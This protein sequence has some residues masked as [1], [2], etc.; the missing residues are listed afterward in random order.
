MKKRLPF[1]P[2]WLNLIFILA[3]FALGAFHEYLCA[4]LS[5][6]LLTALLIRFHRKKELAFSASPVNVILL[7][8]PFLY[9]LT[10]LWATDRGIALMGF[11]K[12]LPLS[13]FT[14]LLSDGE[15]EREE[16][17][18]LL[19]FVGGAQA[20]LSAGLMQIPVLKGF[21]SVSGRLAGFF[22]YPNT[23]A[24]FLLM[25]VLVLL[26]KE[27]LRL[28]DYLCLAVLVGGI[29]YSGSR[30]TLVITVVFAAAAVLT[31]TDKKKRWI[32][33]IGIIA[34]IAAAGIYA[35]AGGGYRTIGRFLSIS[36][37][38]STFLGRLLYWKD[39]LRLVLQHPFGLGYM[40]WYFR[41]FANQTGVYTVQFIHNDYL[42][43]LLDVG[44][45]G[46][47]L[48]AFMLAA[49]FF[50]KKA[51]RRKR[52]MLLA[53][54]GHLLMDFDLQFTAMWLL[55]AVLLYTPGERRM[56]LEKKAAVAAPGVALALLSLW[57]GLSQGLYHFKLYKPAAATWPGNTFAQ[58]AVMQNESDTEKAALTAERVLRRNPYVAEAY[59]AKASAAFSA[60]DILT[61]AD[62][63]RK[64]IENAPYRMEYYDEYCYMLAVAFDLYRQQDDPTGMKFCRNQMLAVPDMLQ[65][66]EEKTDP[67]AYRI[68]DKPSFALS[69]ESETYIVRVKEIEIP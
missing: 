17:L 68:D 7:L 64:Q 10:A 36:L 8:F 47:G 56:T 40:G 16:L 62:A 28:S 67:L 31:G 9:L 2:T 50:S 55:L 48:F 14:L 18:S 30:T 57:I 3:S 34:L 32:A 22:Q 23:F 59:G 35:V 26:T 25:G 6:V 41:Q 52:L 20:V 27:R 37:T 54:G 65:E 13:L 19:P 1:R 49:A 45:A 51:D 53:F 58:V 69:E 61:M 43:L 11:V 38:E 24:L 12:L 44:A 63:K 60:G 4:I 29:L 33:L 42:Q 15:E 5:V 39:G 21:F 66:L 46:F